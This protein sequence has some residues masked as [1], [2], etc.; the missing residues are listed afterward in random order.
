MKSIACD[1]DG[2]IWDG[3]IPFL[4]IYNDLYNTNLTVNDITKWGFFPEEVF[5]SI[6]EK[7]SKKIM[8]YK[9]YK[10]IFKNI[11]ALTH[12]FHIY[13]LTHGL[14]NEEDIEKKLKSWGILKGIIYDEI[15]IED[16]TKKKIH[17]DFD[18]FI[19]DNPQMVQD[20]QEYPEKRLLLFDRPWNRNYSFDSCKI[21]RVF[22]WND[23]YNYLMFLKG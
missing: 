13:F 17:R 2:I 6:Y 9:P 19:D 20:I 23:I 18:Y 7:S 1:L 22:D 14:Y 11:F 8:D 10:D 21:V 15:I 16:Q 12:Y 5:W 3:H 4:E